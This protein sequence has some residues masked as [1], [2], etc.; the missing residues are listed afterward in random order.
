VPIR[1]YGLK[2]DMLLFLQQK[3]RSFVNIL[4]VNFDM[5]NQYVWQKYFDICIV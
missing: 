4:A 1:A 5:P 3:E 2:E